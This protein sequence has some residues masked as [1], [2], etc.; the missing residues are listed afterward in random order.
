MNLLVHPSKVLSVLADET[1]LS[2]ARIEVVPTAQILFFFTFAS[3]TISQASCKIMSS[4]ESILCLERSSTSTGLKV[5]RP[6]CNVTS[7]NF[8]PLI[9]SLFNKCFEK[10]KPAVGAEFFQNPSRVRTQKPMEGCVGS[11]VLLHPRTPLLQ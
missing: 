6:T 7:A 4:S 8:T 2:M 5:P 10:C 11:V 3:F 1:A 9:S